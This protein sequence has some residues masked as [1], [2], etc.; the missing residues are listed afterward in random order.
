[1]IDMLVP[2]LIKPEMETF[3]E[4]FC[5]GA[6]VG[7]S[8]LD[9]KLTKQLVLNYMDVNVASFWKILCSDKYNELIK[10]VQNYDPN[11]SDYFHFRDELKQTNLSSLERAFQFYVINRCSFSGIMMS[12][13]K[14]NMSDRWNP[15]A[16]EK[17]VK[18]IHQMADRI[19][20]T[21]R[22]AKEVIEE[23]YWNKQNVIFVDPPY[24]AKGKVLYP[25]SF[26]QKDHY[27]LA[28]LINGLMI[29]YPGCADVLITYDDEDY[30]KEIYQ[31]SDHFGVS[32]MSNVKF[33]YYKRK[34]SV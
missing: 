23:Y 11:R 18:H 24:Y 14:S 8:M 6:S 25:L 19:V 5:G 34:Y 16:F 32:K 27:E 17:K 28:E 22:D 12:G 31:Y 20:V 10:L 1:M 13:P 29:E 2:K 3:V 26:C 9:A 15:N 21:N 4:P 7:L 33:V 30:I